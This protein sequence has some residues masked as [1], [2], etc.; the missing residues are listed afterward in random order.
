M[1]PGRVRIAQKSDEEEVMELCRELHRENGIF[2]MNEDKVRAMLRKAFDRQGGLLGVIGEPGKI[3]GM[4]FMYL[5][6]FWYSD[7]PHW[8]EI[9]NFVRQPHRKSKD[10]LELL[11][12]A[13]W[14][15]DSSNIPLLI[16]VISNE[17][18][19]GKVRL[20]QRKFDAPIG[21]FFFYKANGH[22]EANVIA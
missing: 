16:G 11:D 15:A 13:R 12:F 19:A 8:E 7:D 14:A 6:S 9:L 3:E 18:T 22:A 5:S 4:I 1:F 2:A 21:N 17:R 20:Y 10:A